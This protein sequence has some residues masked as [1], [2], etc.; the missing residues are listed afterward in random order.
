MFKHI[1]TEREVKFEGDDLK[2]SKKYLNTKK[3]KRESIQ[4]LL[5]NFLHINFWGR[6][7]ESKYLRL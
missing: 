2:V 4:L 5:L 6:E 1:K 7:K 3:E